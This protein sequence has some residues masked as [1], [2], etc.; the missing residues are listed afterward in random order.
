[1]NAGWSHLVVPVALTEPD[2]E[3]HRVPGH[4]AAGW[5]ELHTDSVEVHEGAESELIRG[6]PAL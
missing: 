1:M 2:Q 4:E 5:L 6:R 3:G